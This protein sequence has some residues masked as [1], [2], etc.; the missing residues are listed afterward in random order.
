MVM[1][2]EGLLI[3]QNRTA[4]YNF[5]EQFSECISKHVSVM[6]KQRYVETLEFVVLFLFTKLIP[7]QVLKSN[8][9]TAFPPLK[10]KD[11]GRC[12]HFTQ[13]FPIA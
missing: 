6:Q 13:N 7:Y 2:A 1:Q 4:C 10:H 8:I 3:E 5:V 9:F 12:L 11:I